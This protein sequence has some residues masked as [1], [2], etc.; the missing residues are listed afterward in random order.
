MVEIMRYQSKDR[1]EINGEK[2][3]KDVIAILSGVEEVKDL[4]EE[5]G[6]CSKSH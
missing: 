2:F 4:K 1:I 5:W 3:S 6:R